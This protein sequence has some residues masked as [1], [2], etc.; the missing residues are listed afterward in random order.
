MKSW[1]AVFLALVLCLSMT[2]CGD[3]SIM[4]LGGG[5]KEE[6]HKVEIPAAVLD[7]S[8]EDEILLNGELKDGVYTNY[9]FG[10][11]F[12]TPEG[13]SIS[14]LNDEAED[15]TKILSLREAYEEEMGGISFMAAPESFGQYIILSIRAL[16]DDELGLSEEEV[17][18]RNN[19]RIWEINKILG[20]DRGPEL[21]TAMFA[22]KEH[23][24][25]IQTSETK[26]GEIL[27]VSFYL[28]KGDFVCDISIS[29]PNGTLEQM[30][31]LF[32]KL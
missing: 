7:L 2:A 31:A 26:E 22:G 14:R 6:E 20:E 3:T 23:P 12:T 16:R 25:G 5:D 17:V 10:I 32:E 27:Y 4:S 1:I 21:G 28:P 30:T 18:K 13:W 9:Y 8:E 29:T 19:E 24:M 15:T 11:R